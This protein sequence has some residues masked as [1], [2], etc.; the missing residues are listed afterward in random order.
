MLSSGPRATDNYRDLSFAL[1]FLGLLERGA[2]EGRISSPLDIFGWPKLQ[3][4]YCCSRR[5]SISHPDDNK[6]TERLLSQH[7]LLSG[8]N[9]R[10]TLI[11]S[12]LI[13]QTSLKADTNFW[14]SLRVNIFPPHGAV[15]LLGLNVNRRPIRRHLLLLTPIM[16]YNPVDPPHTFQSIRRVIKEAGTKGILFT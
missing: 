4:R 9:L 6:D 7:P 5:F 1:T 11:F 10:T 8:V 13:Y 2:S 15:A 12:R 3:S 14:P 16:G